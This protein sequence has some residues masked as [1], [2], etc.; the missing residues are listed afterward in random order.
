MNG[1]SS[2]HLRFRSYFHADT[3]K[4]YN[5][6]RDYDPAVGRY[7]QPDPLGL[8]GGLNRFGYVGGAPLLYRDVRGLQKSCADCC[9]KA[10]AAA[11]LTGGTVMCCGGQ[12]FACLFNQPESPPPGAGIIRGCKKKHEESHFEDVECNPSGD[13]QP[14]FGPRRPQALGE[15]E[16]YQEEIKCLDI[17]KCGGNQQCETWL[18]DTIESLHTDAQDRGFGCV[19]R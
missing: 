3:G 19:F 10:P 12:K 5:Y 9:S 1:E 2:L 11:K 4:H 18:K 13:Y 15:C 8:R 17:K 6:F 7:V 14:G 16:R